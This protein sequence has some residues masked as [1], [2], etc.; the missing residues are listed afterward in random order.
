MITFPGPL[1][2]SGISVFLG[3]YLKHPECYREGEYRNVTLLG[4]LGWTQVARGRREAA[5]SLRLGTVLGIQ[6]HGVMLVAGM[7]SNSTWLRRCSASGAA[8]TCPRTSRPAS[9]SGPSPARGPWCA[10]A[11]R[12]LL[13]WVSVAR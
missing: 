2:S 5:T 1:P 3:N 13:L 7:H 6:P 8:A 12:W 11:R 4:D 10:M 9:A